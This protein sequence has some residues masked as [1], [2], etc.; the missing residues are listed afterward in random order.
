MYIFLPAC[1]YMY[2]YVCMYACMH[3]CMYVYTHKHTHTHIPAGNSSLGQQQHAGNGP[4]DLTLLAS[5]VH[6][7]KY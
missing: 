7:Y 5:L 6:K 3:V 1:I 2:M 4:P